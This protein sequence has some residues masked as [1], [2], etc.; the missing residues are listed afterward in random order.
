MTLFAYGTLLV[1]EIWFAA[2]GRECPSE[3]ATLPGYEILRVKGGDFP[4]I[5]QT[6]GGNEVPGRVFSGLDV[7]IF[8]RLDAYED[9]FYERVGVTLLNRR[10]NPVESEAYV[11]PERHRDVLSDDSWTLDW[12]REHAMAEYMA[13]LFS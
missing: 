4:G 1:P 13:R 3:D 11:I 12:F 9:S 10:G 2:A 5:I 7:E 8:E 6:A